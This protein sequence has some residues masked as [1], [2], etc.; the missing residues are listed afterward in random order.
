[1]KVIEYTP[2]MTIEAG[3]LVTGMPNDI[4]HSWPGSISKSGLDLVLRSPAHYL[5]AARRE[6]TRAMEIG[7]A[8][9]TA[10]LE[11][12]RFK[13]EYVL[14]KEVKDRRQPEYK[15]AVAVHGSERVLVSSEVDDVVGMAEAV[16]ANPLASKWLKKDGMRELTVFANDP[17]TG[18]LVRCRFDILTDD[19]H[20][21]DLKKSIDAR[22]DAFSRAVDNYAYHMQDA[23]YSDVFEW[24]TGFPLESFRFLVIEPSLPHASMVYRLDETARR[25]GRRMYREALDIYADCVFHGHWPSYQSTDDEVISLPAWRLNQIE[26]E[27]EVVL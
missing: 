8:I 23:F 14:L 7:T 21:V 11:P 17:E 20:A 22:P 27:M 15:A 6:P 13:N 26:N 3:M 5:Y 19:G 10:L 1:M 9:H 2:G 12:E 18:V 25:E 24:A 4:Y 16:Y